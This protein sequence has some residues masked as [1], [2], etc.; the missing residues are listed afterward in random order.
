MLR[1]FVC[2]NDMQNCAKINEI[3]EKYILMHNLVMN[4]HVLNV[5]PAQ[6]LAFLQA[7]P[8]SAG[9]YFVDWNF[10][11]MDGGIEFANT[12]RKYDPRGF[13][14]FMAA[15]DAAYKLIFR[16][17][18]EAMDCISKSDAYFTE[19]VRECL[20]KTVERFIAKATFLQDNYILKL[21]DDVKSYRG[22]TLT[23]DSMVSIDIGEII[24]FETIPGE[25]N[26]V[27]VY[28]SEGALSFRGSLK[29]VEEEMK[30]RRNFYRCQNSLLVNLDKVLALDPVRCKL[31]LDR[32]LFMDIAGRKI[33]TLG[34]KIDDYNK[35]ANVIS[36]L[37]IPSQSSD[38]IVLE[39]TE[40]PLTETGVLDVAAILEAHGLSHVVD[41]TKAKV[42]KIEEVK[43]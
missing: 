21:S 30:D 3:A 36:S 11:R 38:V 43:L 37:N 6:V 8:G 35:D 33:K 19:R 20:D 22:K 29:K 18:L 34:N 7:N 24:C 23:K 39:L 13:I 4:V 9:L 10:G 16:H 32:G 40:A 17:K 31:S 5:L 1:I 42:T 2:D 28:T 25:K 27:T 14:V 26:T 15:D 41:L 12:V